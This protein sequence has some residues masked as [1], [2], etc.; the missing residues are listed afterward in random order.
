MITASTL[1]ALHR[2]Q[3][4]HCDKH[5]VQGLSQWWT[6]PHWQCGSVNHL[7]ETC[8]AY[9]LTLDRCMQLQEVEATSCSEFRDK[10][11]DTVPHRRR[12]STNLAQAG[13]LGRPEVRTAL[14]LIGKLLVRDGIIQAQPLSVLVTNTITLITPQRTRGPE[15][16]ALPQ[17]HPGGSGIHTVCIIHSGDHWDNLK[18]PCQGPAGNSN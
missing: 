4:L 3:P 6:D 15:Q 8:V 9:E 11:L 13:G 18:L 14:P 12:R 10:T 16:Q 7:D 5:S 17:G 1:V 2:S